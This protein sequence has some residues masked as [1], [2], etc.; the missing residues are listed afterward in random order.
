MSFLIATPVR[1]RAT[2]FE[3]TV[4]LMHSAGLYGGWMPMG[5][6]SDIY[7][8]R[9][10]LVSEFMKMKHDQLVFIDSDIGFTRTDLQD[11]VTSPAPLVSGLYAG[12][13]NAMKP[14]YVPLEKDAPLP[15]EGLIDAKY[16]PCGF[17]CIHRSV[18]EAIKPLVAEYGPP[19]APIWQFFNGM[20]EERMLL[21][22]DYSF[23]VNARK[24]GIVPKVN[25]KIRVKHDGRSIPE[26]V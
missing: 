24:A 14:V 22:E 15:K 25:C 4:G 3:Y 23:C 26:G 12:K 13:D 17:L 16:V 5:G 7:V 21:S 20:I 8:A 2:D 11:L 18:F 10:G 9:N 6:Q 1:G 19:E